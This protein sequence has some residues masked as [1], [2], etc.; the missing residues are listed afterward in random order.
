MIGDP[1]SELGR[2]LC[3]KA[4]LPGR[5]SAVGRLSL[6][7][8]SPH[9]NNPVRASF[10]LAAVSPTGGRIAFRHTQYERLDFTGEQRSPAPGDRNSSH[11]GA[12]TSGLMPAGPALRRIAS[13]SMEL[14]SSCLPS[15]QSCAVSKA[16]TSRHA[17]SKWFS[18]KIPEVDINSTC[19]D[20]DGGQP[21]GPRGELL[22]LLNPPLRIAH[23]TT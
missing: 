10:V 12:A 2:A 14:W 17:K 15:S 7:S 4:R 11:R 1:T 23:E 9:W 8:R 16:S 13:L 22:P 18:V 3:H 20:L 19:T 5:H 21:R 6:S